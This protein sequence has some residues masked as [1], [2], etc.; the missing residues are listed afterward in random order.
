MSIDW[1]KLIWNALDPNDS[2][3]LGDALKSQALASIKGWL[4]E[5]KTQIA[6]LLRGVL[7]DGRLDKS[8]ASALVSALVSRWSKVSPF[9]HSF[10][11]KLLATLDGGPND[12][13]ELTLK[14]IAAAAAGWLSE[15]TRDENLMQFIREIANGALSVNEARDMLLDFVRK[16]NGAS[17]SDALA[18]L[19]KGKVLLA[20]V[21]LLVTALRQAD[22]PAEP[23]DTLQDHLT[24][25]RGYLQ[26]NSNSVLNKALEQVIKGEHAP[27]AA[28]A[29]AAV[30][31]GDEV[32]T[33]FSKELT[34]RLRARLESA[35]TD[36]LRQQVVG[37]SEPQAAALAKAIR[38][39]WS[40]ERTLWA[41]QT[42]KDELVA[43]GFAE[44]HYPTWVRVRHVLYAV[45]ESLRAGAVVSTDPLA[46]PHVF[47]AAQIKPGTPLKSLMAAEGQEEKLV[48]RIKW[49]CA[50][51]YAD[52]PGG[53][54][55][56]RDASVPIDVHGVQNGVPAGKVLH[57]VNAVLLWK[58][59]L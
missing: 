50:A 46:R 17:A 28:A 1:K 47:A 52:E 27:L 56:A 42:D 31:K 40:G 44:E 10:T 20:D 14:E 36:Q 5:D 22:T 3:Q 11:Q 43:A 4:D 30:M 51:E 23:G 41:Q 48:K 6:G 53:A 35:L 37:I 45:G 9:E 55:L 7:A 18:A 8:D 15:Q 34:Q 29:L 2:L 39:L 38:E 12:D 26:G 19:L 49:F 25:L 24:T 57:Y 54:I 59:W 33:L 13:A 21:L 58:D 32:T 16:E